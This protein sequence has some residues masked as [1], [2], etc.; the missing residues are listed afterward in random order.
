MVHVCGKSNATGSSHWTALFTH[1]QFAC[2]VQCINFGQVWLLTS[3]LQIVLSR[4][5][6]FCHQWKHPWQLQCCF[7]KHCVFRCMALLCI[8]LSCTSLGWDCGIFGSLSFFSFEF[9]V[10]LENALKCPL[11][12]MS[13]LGSSGEIALASE[14]DGR[15]SKWQLQTQ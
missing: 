7:F 11:C 4:W 5:S 12:Q 8:Q 1:I 15:G 6:K 14:S 2:S 9:D 10:L 3:N 13:C